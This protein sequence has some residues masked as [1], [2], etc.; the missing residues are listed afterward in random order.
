MKKKL[1]V[2]GLPGAGKTYLSKSLSKMLDAVWLHADMIRKVFNDWDFSLEGRLRQ[3]K[4]MNDLAVEN[5]KKGR[6]V[7]ADFVCPTE[8]TR[9]NFNADYLIWV[10][11]IQ[12]GRFENTNLIFEP[13]KKFD[14]RVTSQNAEFW[15]EKIIENLNKN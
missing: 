6:F 14:F 12:K 5:V 15:A 10:D 2:M 4:R 13:P 1:L 9:K 7:I 8:K 3:S 11:T